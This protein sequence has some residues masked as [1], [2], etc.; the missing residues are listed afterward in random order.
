MRPEFAISRATLT[1]HTPPTLAR[2]RTAGC[3]HWDAPY[4]PH[5]PPRPWY[6]LIHSGISHALGTTTR[7]A[8]ARGQETGGLSSRL[9]ATAN[10]DHM[11]PKTKPMSSRPGPICSAIQ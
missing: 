7:A 5:G 10:G 2:A 8:R 6:D 3:C 11:H 4:R 9:T 1:S